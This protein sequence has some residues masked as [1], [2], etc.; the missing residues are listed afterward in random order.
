MKVL[1]AM[2]RLLLLFWRGPTMH[3]LNIWS[4][5]EELS[6]PE[7][8]VRDWHLSCPERIMKDFEREWELELE[9]SV[10]LEGC[11]EKKQ[12]EVMTCVSD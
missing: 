9:K 11:R 3:W 12:E 8:I 7:N 1:D 2:D 4:C 5:V 10:C 6:C